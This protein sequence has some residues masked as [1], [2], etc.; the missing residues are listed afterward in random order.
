MYFNQDYS[1]RIFREVED[2]ASRV[3]LLKERLAKQNVSVR[4]EHYWKL[5]YVRRTFAEFKCS[6]EQ[7]EEGD[8]SQCNRDCERIEAT[9]NKLVRAVD[10]LLATIP[11]KSLT[12]RR[13]SK[14]SSA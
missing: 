5:A 14:Q 12:P 4:L 3:H 11:V 2:I 9:W 1:H 13:S 8:D 10:A 6:V 7:L